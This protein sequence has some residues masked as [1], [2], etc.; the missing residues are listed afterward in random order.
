MQQQ[1]VVELAKPSPS[2]QHLLARAVISSRFIPSH[3]NLLTV[4]S[5]S[6]NILV[7]HVTKGLKTLTSVSPEWPKSGTGQRPSLLAIS[8]TRMLWRPSLLTSSALSS[9]PTPGAHSPRPCTSG[10]ASCP[11]TSS[12]VAVSTRTRS[13]SR[14]GRPSPMCCPPATDVTSAT[15]ARPARRRSRESPTPCHKENAST[16]SLADWRRRCKRKSNSYP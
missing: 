12:T 11:A 6:A 10:T 9:R 1:Q 16:S 2:Y 5:V 8:T 3:N 14:Q 4:S 13:A 15:T 7:S